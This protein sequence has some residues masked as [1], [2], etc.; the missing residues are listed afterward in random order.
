MSHPNQSIFCSD[1]N[2]TFRS[3]RALKNHQQRFHFIYSDNLPNYNYISS[4]LIVPFSTEQFSLM[5]KNACEQERF[6]LGEF[7]SKLF[8]C[9]ICSLSFPTLNTLNYHH[10]NQHEQYEYHLCQNIL[11]EIILQV[12]QNSRTVDDDFQSMKYLLAKQASHF[13]LRDKQ[14]TRET[15]SIKHEHHR[16]IFPSCE[17]QNRTCANLCLKNLSSYHK[18]IRNYPYKIPIIP[19]GNPFTQGSIV[20]TPSMNSKES[21]DIN[22][23][24]SQSKRKLLDQSINPSPKKF[25]PKINHSYSKL[26]FDLLVFNYLLYFLARSISSMSSTSSTSTRSSSKNSRHQSITSLKRSISPTITLAVERSSEKRRQQREQRK[27]KTISSSSIKIH[28][29]IEQE[30][31]DDEIISIK[32]KKPKHRQASN[33]SV[34]YVQVIT[35]DQLSISSLNNIENLKSKSPSNDDD[36]ILCHSPVKKTS[37]NGVHKINNHQVLCQDIRI[38]IKNFFFF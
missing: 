23:K 25:F 10:L 32:S 35:N 15:R 31:D 33:S 37:V 11:Y 38:R 19:K 7:T 21:L 14:L 5:A 2:L 16:R 36:I 8:Q 34:E 30:N 4:Y 13:G 29:D 26:F 24:R 27:A 28:D 20:S 17:H 3:H 6:P 9:Q 12:E 18:L 22:Q 1:C